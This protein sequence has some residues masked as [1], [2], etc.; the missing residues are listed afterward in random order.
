MPRLRLALVAACLLFDAALARAQTLTMAVEA[1]FGLDPHYL[2]AGPNMA[3]ARNVYD[4][5]INRDAESRFVPGIVE[6][7]EATGPQTWELRLRRGVTF[8][9]GSP[10]TAD[11]VAFSIARVPNVPNNPGPYT[12]NLRTIS[13]VEVVDPH[14]VRLHTDQPN[15]V[16][17]GQLTNIFVVSKRVAEGASTSD[18]NSGRAA[19][20][21]G[22][23]RVEQ[24]RG[25][26]GMSIARNPTYWGEAPAY[27]RVE[28]RVIG[29]DASRLAALLSGDVDLIES[30]PPADVERLQRDARV[31]VFRRNSDRIMY[32]LPNLRLEQFPL[33]TDTAGQPLARNP[34]RD[35]RVRRALS[36]AIDRQAL[37]ARALDGQ[38]VP[39][40][41][42][43]PE[44]F[45]GFDPGIAIP[46]ADPA[47]ARALLAEAGYPNG[48]G[49]TLGCPN[50]RFVNDARV[51]QAAG[52][53]LTRAGFQV[54][55]E[56]Q[57]W[58]V[59]SP[60]TLAHRNDLPLMLYGLSLSSSRDASYILST[61]VH[62]RV[63]EQAFGQGNRGGFSDARLD[64]M[65]DAVIGRADEGREAELR[66]VAAAAAEEVP[67]I[68]L[69]NQV[70]IVA[71]KRGVT[72][73]PRMDEQMVA[74]QARPAG[75]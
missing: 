69:Y 15:P 39:T 36:L 27:A 17:P 45:G 32:L 52:Q 6:S 72:Y 66:R 16:L 56:T 19:I 34:L 44:Q 48:F 29:N 51:C 60:R 62:T 21:T 40:V 55:V 13:R 61:A 18:F 59:F 33:L 2:F 68:P 26:E 58:N 53:M 20:G 50:N 46:A 11:D 67:F 3:A 71:A 49:L 28:I 70:V 24:V 43:V 10:F 54:R 42:M 37:A 5:L 9:D 4:S 73:T 74:I 7:W 57:P 23:F 12:S 63:P 30:V 47:R 75:R 35:V 14:T 41:Q 64:A 38:A 25:Q 65:I 1:P 8:H 31:S 22:P